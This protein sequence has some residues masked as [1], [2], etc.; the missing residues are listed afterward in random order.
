MTDV[1]KTQFIWLKVTIN[2][3]LIDKKLKIEN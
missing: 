2:Q 3:F 1:N